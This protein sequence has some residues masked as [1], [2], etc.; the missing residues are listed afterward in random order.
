MYFFTSFSLLIAP[1]LYVYRN[2]F[3]G[4][5]FCATRATRATCHHSTSPPNSTRH[6][7]ISLFCRKNIKCQVAQVAQLSQSIFCHNINNN[8]IIYYIIIL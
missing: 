3:V 5:H 7:I 4:I 2:G 1:F 6:F 8:N